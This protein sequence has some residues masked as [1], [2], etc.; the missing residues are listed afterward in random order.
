MSGTERR[1]STGGL[2]RASYY[3]DGNEIRDDGSVFCRRGFFSFFCFVS[4]TRIFI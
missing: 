2:L 3:V 4:F 1:F